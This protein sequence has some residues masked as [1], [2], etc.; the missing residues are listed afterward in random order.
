MCAYTRLSL[1][2]QE[3]KSDESRVKNVLMD[4]RMCQPWYEYITCLFYFLLSEEAEKRNTGVKSKLLK[5]IAAAVEV[6]A[7]ITT[8]R[9]EPSSNE[10][11]LLAGAG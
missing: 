4:S 1:A 3:I 7:V 5:L 2:L 9:T 11:N 10:L 6:A 8:G